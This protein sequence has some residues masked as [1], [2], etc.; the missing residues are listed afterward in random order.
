MKP[1]HELSVSQWK[2]LLHDPI[3]HHIE[4]ISITG[5]EALLSPHIIELIEL[6]IQRI[7]KLYHVDIVSNGFASELIRDKTIKIATLCNEHH[8]N[9]SISIS[10]DGIGKKHNEIRRIPLAFQK[11]SKTIHILKNLQNTYSFSL[12]IGSVVMKQTVSQIQK[13]QNWASK[14][15]IPQYF[16]PVGFHKAYLQN[17]DEKNTTDI[18]DREKEQF[19]HFLK[20]KGKR[21]SWKDIEAYYWKDMYY[22]YKNNNPR[23]TP[24]AFLHDEFAIDAIGNVYY[25]L[26]EKSIGNILPSYS[27][28]NIYFNPKNI[29]YRTFIKNNKCSHCNSDCDIRKAIAFDAKKYLWFFITNKPWYGIRFYCKKLNNFITRHA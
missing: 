14:N 26:S 1:L 3:F 6:Y 19:L 23:T 18:S 25:C 12:S 20:I 24:C 27:I 13:L 28:T 5:G 15:S 17:L 8:I 29:Q 9:F 16:Q 4:K 2:K 22:M 7:P 21:K 10:L 11:V